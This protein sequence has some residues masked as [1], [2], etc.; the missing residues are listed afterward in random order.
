MREMCIYFFAEMLQD[1]R[2]RRRHH[3]AKAADGSKPEGVREFIEQSEIGGRA[4]STSPSFEH[5]NQLA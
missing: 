2:Y 3:L 4:F 1:G 5:L